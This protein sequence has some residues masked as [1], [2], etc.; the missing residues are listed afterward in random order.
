MTESN[1]A[2]LSGSACA[3]GTPKGYEAIILAGGLGTRLRSVVSDVPKCMAPVAGRPFL[4]YVINY[5]RSEGVESFIFSLG[6]KHEIVENYLADQFATL[7]YTIV[8]EEEPLGTGGATRLACQQAVSSNVLLANGDTLFRVNL[9]AL[10]LFHSEKNAVCTLSLKPM[11]DFDRYGVV[12]LNKDQTIK[13]FREKQFYKSGLINGGLYILNV[14]QFLR[15]DFAEKFSFEKDYLEASLDY[16][17][18]GSPN[19]KEQKFAG[20][21]EDNYFID[22]GIP[23]DFSKAQLDFRSVNI[24]LKKITKNWTLFLDRDGVINEEKAESYVFSPD[25]F[26]FYP[27]VLSALK[28]F[29]D[30]FGKII[31][32]T[33]QR[34]VGK[35]LMTEKDLARIHQKLVTTARHEGATIDGIYYCSSLNNKDPYRKPNPGMAIQARKD[36]PGI[37]FSRSIMVGNNLSDMQFGK[38]VGMFTAF[39]NTTHPNQEFPHPDIDMAFDSLIEF[40]RAL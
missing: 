3:G 2:S 5:L 6:Y 8:I 17:V 33:N 30:K 4:F 14:N 18:G 19:A 25:E 31:V 20:F 1:Q 36:F 15:K 38:S 35:E 23:E 24:D 29:S 26:I 21:V 12:E 37:D 22:I 39:I 28:L 27:G 32:V 10:F 13:N 40:A 9:K 34:G 16:N 7:N 11:I